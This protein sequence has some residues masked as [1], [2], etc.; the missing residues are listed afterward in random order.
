MVSHAE[1]RSNEH[2]VDVVLVPIPADL[3]VAVDAVAGDEGR[4]DFV[5]AAVADRVKRLRDVRA[6][7]GYLSAEDAPHWATEESTA[8][9]LRDIRDWPDPWSDGE[10]IAG[11]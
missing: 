3:A 1:N 11:A 4:E 9:W 10:D 7:I 2:A 8:A 5:R 6:F